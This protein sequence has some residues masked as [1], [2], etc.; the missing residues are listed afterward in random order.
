MDQIH[1]IVVA[2]S[3]I[4]Q[5]GIAS[6]LGKDA[7]IRI[8]ET[9]RDVAEIPF[10]LSE[11]TCDVILLDS[12]TPR[13][14]AAALSQQLLPGQ[15]RPRLLVLS[16]SEDV[17]ELRAT[18]GLGVKGYGISRHL[19][20]DEIPMAVHMVAHGRTWAC[21]RTTELLVEAITHLHEESA[22]PRPRKLPISERELEVLLLVA[23]GAREPDIAT[24]LCL[25]RNTVK[26]YFRRIRQKLQ[27]ETI[28]A[29]VR[30]AMVQGLL[31]SNPSNVREM[32]DGR[33]QG[34]RSTTVLSYPFA[35]ASA[36]SL[37]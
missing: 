26:T 34:T 23:N 32:D 36:L 35:K 30:L 24:Q 15:D 37:R 12:D 29:A 21:P 31:P 1:V 8:V 6:V 10:P 20:P 9:F 2:G 13:R 22:S 14:D 7:A 18:L 25:S 19:D 4:L 17:D 27:A 3:P 5:T 33:R 28:A 16:D 11:N